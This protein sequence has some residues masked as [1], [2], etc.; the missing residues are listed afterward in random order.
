VRA[1]IRTGALTPDD[2]VPQVYL[3]KL[4]EGRDIVEPEIVPM[5][6]QGATAG[7][8]GLLFRAVIPCRTSGTHGLTV[9]V[10]PHH[11]DLGNPHATGLIAWASAGSAGALDPTV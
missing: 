11:V 9:R 10:L 4:H 2:I 8:D 5:E 6:M 3:G 1:W 7:G